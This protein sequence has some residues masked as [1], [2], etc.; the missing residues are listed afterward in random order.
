MV[1]S[2][3]NGQSV[4]KGGGS[5]QNQPFSMEFRMALNVFILWHC[6]SLLMGV[7]VA[8]AIS[9]QMFEE[10]SLCGECVEKRCAAAKSW[11]KKKT[12]NPPA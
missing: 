5:P 10:S 2:A 9:D 4:Q 7:G 12:E 8:V 1:E 6:D 3:R 11:R